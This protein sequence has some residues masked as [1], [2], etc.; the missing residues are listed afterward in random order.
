M[1]QVEPGW[2]K[3]KGDTIEVTMPKIGL[4]D[5]DFIDE[6]KTKPFFESGK[7]TPKDREA[8]YRKA[9][10]QII[11]HCLTKENLKAAQD[12]GEAQMKN[13]MTQLG[14]KKITILFGD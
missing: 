12:N 11:Q 5:K 9:Y 14:Y 13:M 4:L 10:R 2:I 8:L 1:H 7:W 6:A 3:T